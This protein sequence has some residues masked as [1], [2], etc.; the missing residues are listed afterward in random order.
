MYPGQRIGIIAHSMGGVVASLALTLAPDI[1]DSIFAL[2]ALSTPFEGH[3]VNSHIGF[4]VIY[5]TIHNFWKSEEANKIFTLSI[6]G[7]V[8]D[9][10]VPP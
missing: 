5:K 2:I 9:I 3:P 1:V 6:T 7:G 4:P 8:R 10:M